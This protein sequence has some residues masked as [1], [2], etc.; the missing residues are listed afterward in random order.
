MHGTAHALLKCS[1]PS[2][3]MHIFLSGCLDGWISMDREIIGR[4]YASA[5]KLIIAM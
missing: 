2:F 3:F 4:N 5:A 1:S